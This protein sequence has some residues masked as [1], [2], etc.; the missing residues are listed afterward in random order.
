[1]H[2]GLRSNLHFVAPSRQRPSF[3]KFSGTTLLIYRLELKKNYELGLVFSGEELDFMK[4][5]IL[6]LSHL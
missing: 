4:I 5:E 3:K 2:F 1:M 6:N